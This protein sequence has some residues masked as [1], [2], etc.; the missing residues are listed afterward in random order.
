MSHRLFASAAAALTASVI[1]C[2][3]TP[4][5]GQT[6]PA[7]TKPVEKTAGTN[8]AW[9]PP[10][11]PDGHTDLQ[12][13][14][15]NSTE[16]PLERPKGLGA[17]EFYTE[18]ELADL[19]KKDEQRVTL[20]KEEGRPTEPGTN[21]DVHYD[22]TQYGLDRG[23]AKLSWSQRTSMI[24]GEQGTVPPMLPAARKRNADIAAK[25]R[26]HDLDGPENLSLSARCIVVAQE[27]VPML[28]GGYNNN[29]QIVQG[30]GVVAI[31][32][33]MDHSV[34]LIPI[35]GRPHPPADIRQFKGDSIGH[36]EGNTLVV[37]STN[38]TARNP[39]HGSGDK[40]HVVERFTRVDAGT[41]LYRFTVEDP[42]TWDKPWTAET[43]WSKVAGPIFEYACHEGNY[44]LRN[45]LHGARVADEEAADKKTAR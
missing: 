25:N 3:N 34:R 32:H 39:F 44:S 41:V 16:T 42:E 10:R 11:T 27:S 1:L 21:A 2:T 30:A 40:L 15:T 7:A 5:S 24:V 23:Q 43:A 26:G 14:W 45:T 18:A 38:F 35:D 37:D 28:P 19:I 12:G 9:T 6:A 8:K 20:N 31:I 13:I 4:A 29:L 22:Y 17:Q 33:E 36:W